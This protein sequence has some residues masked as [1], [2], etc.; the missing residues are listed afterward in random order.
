MSG[1]KILYIEDNK[2]DFLDI[3]HFLEAT[4]FQVLPAEDNFKSFL[5]LVKSYLME[6]SDETKENLRSY[7]LDI[8][9]NV[10]IIDLSLGVN[11]YA[12]GD[13]V[14]R[15]ILMKTPDLKNIPV[16]YLSG[17]TGKGLPLDANTRY[18]FKDRGP[19]GYDKETTFLDLLGE[20]NTLLPGSKSKLG[21]K[22]DDNF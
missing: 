15:D 12:F 4:N 6:N 1:F 22:I 14:Q 8:I 5:D 3:K 20:I 9:P 13:K 11:E 7:L 10:V 16:V 18:V 17:A 2:K 19:S 21:K